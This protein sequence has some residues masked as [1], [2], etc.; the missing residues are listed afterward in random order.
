[1]FLYGWLHLSGFAVSLDEVKHFRAMDSITPGVTPL[2]AMRERGGEGVAFPSP[3]E[4]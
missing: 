1:M 4:G 2:P 3:S